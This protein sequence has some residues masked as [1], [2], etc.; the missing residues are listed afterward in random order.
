MQPLYRLAILAVLLL[1]SMT[2][3]EA[4]PMCKQAIESSSSN[5]EPF[6]YM[7]SILFMLAMVTGVIGTLIGFLIYMSRQEAAAL[8]A[9]TASR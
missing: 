3:A 5:P 7:V 4:C 2:R 1:G 8:S 9:A 6:A